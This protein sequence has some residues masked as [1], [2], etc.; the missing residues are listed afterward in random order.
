M[1]RQ[2]VNVH[3]II[4]INLINQKIIPS[5][6]YFPTRGRLIETLFIKHYFIQLKIYK[7]AK[8]YLQQNIWFAKKLKISN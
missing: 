3:L 2:R 8:K 6:T 5:L 1:N 7:K 4:I